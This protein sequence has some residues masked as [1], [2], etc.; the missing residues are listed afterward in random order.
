VSS[1]ARRIYN[2][3]EALETKHKAPPRTVPDTFLGD[4]LE[5]Q[6][7]IRDRRQCARGAAVRARALGPV[8]G[9]SR[10]FGGCGKEG[11]HSRGGRG[12]AEERSRWRGIV[13]RVGGERV[14]REREVL[15]DAL[16]EQD[17]VD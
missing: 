2:S 16:L 5:E 14:R 15:R 12:G 1:T 3:L 4:H 7:D 8:P 9:I 10:V 17:V 13:R 11:G 6:L